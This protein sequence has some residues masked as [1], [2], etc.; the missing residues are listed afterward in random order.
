MKDKQLLEAAT[1]YKNLLEAQGILAE[2]IALREVKRM[3]DGGNEE[4]RHIL[5]RHLLWICHHI[6]SILN[7]PSGQSFC[8]RWLGCVEGA[9]VAY[10]ILSV[11]DVRETFRRSVLLPALEDE[12]DAL[13][14]Q[15]R[16]V[17]RCASRATTARS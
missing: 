5:L 14:R 8:I 16:S 13:P 2:R 10:G 17:V 9:L 15:P 3:L 4:D 1:Q 12:L 7:R 11:E 6:P